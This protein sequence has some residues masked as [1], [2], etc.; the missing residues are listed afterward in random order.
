MIQQKAAYI[1]GKQDGRAYASDGCPPLP[2]G[3]AARR[4]NIGSDYRK[5]WLAAYDLG[6]QHG[7]SDA[8]NAG[9]FLDGAR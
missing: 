7:Q 3:E 1:M 2:K 9:N 5:D 8:K 6:F 4:Y